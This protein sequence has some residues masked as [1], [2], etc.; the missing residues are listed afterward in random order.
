MK[1]I[2]TFITVLLISMA[3]F[4]G[5]SCEK[6]N[7][8]EC[9]HHYYVSTVAAT[10]NTKGYDQFICSKCGDSYKD[11]YVDE[12]GEHVGIG[13]CEKCGHDFFQ[14]MADYML[15][16]GNYLND[17]NSYVLHDYY[18]PTD[19]LWSYKNHL[20]QLEVSFIK[21]T[22]SVKMFFIVYYNNAE[23]IYRWG[24]NYTIKSQSVSYQMEGVFDVRGLYDSTNYISYTAS[25]FPN[26]LTLDA[27]SLAA[28]GMKG[29]AAY[30]Q[31]L[32]MNFDASV[33]NWGYINIEFNN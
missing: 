26:Y 33:E 31:V 32:L 20:N 13:E 12:T 4:I 30:L 15:S 17:S 14:E 16:N 25:T 10:C 2:V 8:E 6:N 5:C 22:A 21:D 7:G 11:N 29:I 27:Q 19:I 3:T 23:G 1:R 9:S 18:A 24:M 28:G